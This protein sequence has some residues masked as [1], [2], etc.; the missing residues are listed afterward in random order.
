MPD[1]EKRSTIRSDSLVTTEVGK[2][3]KPIP[4]KSKRGT[5]K[6]SEEGLAPWI[7]ARSFDR[8]ADRGLSST[9]GDTGQVQCWSM[10][11]HIFYILSKENLCIFSQTLLQQNY[12][13]L[14]PIWRLLY[15]RPSPWMKLR[16]LSNFKKTASATTTFSLVRR[17]L[18]SHCRSKKKSTTEK[19]VKSR[20]LPKT[21]IINSNLKRM[22]I[23][24][25]MQVVAL[26]PGVRCFQTAYSPNG[27]YA[28]YCEG[29]N[30][31]NIVYSL[32]EKADKIVSILDEDKKANHQLTPRFKNFLKKKIDRIRERCKNLVT[33]VSTCI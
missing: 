15:W 10:L 29:R 12:P 3:Q 27:E 7:G 5:S 30:G 24:F 4:Y 28:A 26:D 9:E 21:Y 16:R 17:R 22:S 6:F 20:G 32:A 13:S 19:Q 8:D 1:I 2:D 25:Q 18:G 14:K 23:F 31:Y 33:E 11:V